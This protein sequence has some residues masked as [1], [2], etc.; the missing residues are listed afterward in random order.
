[1][2]S[3]E[4]LRARRQHRHSILKTFAFAHRQLVSLEIQVLDSQP[5]AF[6]QPQA[7]AV[8]Q[9]GHQLES[10]GDPGEQALLVARQ[11]DRQPLGPFGPLDLAQ[12]AQLLVQHFPVKKEQR[13]E[14]LVLRG[15]GHL[16]RH[17]QV[18]QEPFHLRPAH[19]A[20][21]AR[22]VEKRCIA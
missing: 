20:R 4:A 18:A 16:A 3:Q 11:H 14:C 21:V 10:A 9:L 15:G 1:M 22:A 8:E 17:G 13:V 19:L 7:C 6:H 12:L 5:H 2:L